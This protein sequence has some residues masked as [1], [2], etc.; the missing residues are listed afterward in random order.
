MARARIW[1]VILILSATGTMASA[2]IPRKIPGRP[3]ATSQPATAEAPAA[4]SRPA[5]PFSP[6]A[7]TLERRT[8]GYTGRSPVIRGTPTS[9]F[10]PIPD[11][12]R[13]GVPPE[14]RFTS[15]P[16]A[17][18]GTRPGPLEPYKQN[19]LKGDY[20]IFGQD[21]FLALSAT[22]D[23]LFETRRLPVPSGTSAK[24]ADSL[25]FFGAGRQYLVNQN[26]ILSMELF[27]GDTAYRPRDWELRFTPVFNFNYVNTQEL[28]LI[29]PD[30]HE[31][32]DR[33]DEWIGLQ[34][35]FF[36]KHLGDLSVNYDFW[37]ARFGIQGF[38]SDFR[39]FLFSDNE[40]GVRLFGTL[41]NFKTHWNVA[42]F[43]QL[44]KDT[45]SGLNAYELRDQ[46]VIIANIYRQDF[47]WLGYTA[48]LSFHANLDSGHGQID[49]NGVIVRPAPI[50]TIH[51]KSVNAYYLGWAGDGHIGRLNLTHQ[52]YWALG[53][54][55]FN[56]IAGRDVDINAQF[57]ALELSYDQDW[58]RY[59]ASFLW[60]SGDDDPFDSHGRGFD[61][62]FENPNFAGGG[63]SLFVRQSIKLTGAGVS[64]VNRNALL[65]DLRT[66]KEQG[67]ANFVNPGLFIYN[68]GADFEI[69]PK[70]KAITNV[71]WLM[72]DDTA[73]IQEL[74]GDD[75]IGRSIGLDYS[76]GLQW[77]PFLN[78]NAI[79]NFGAAALTPSNGFKDIYSSQTLYSVF[80]GVT[81]SY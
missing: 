55:S 14:S 53:H 62:I 66:S 22:S 30:V 54:E 67:Q 36:E 78:N 50:G 12:W 77:R 1:V 74:L 71:S 3:G 65:P 61:S 73:V 56:P 2:Q 19:V 20:P 7:Q 31:G 8:S 5:E 75:K 11:R 42:W 47:I 34:E 69:T 40:P 79:I 57:F 46:Q 15:E 70:L 17:F 43:S 37:A 16:G 44:E 64:L 35:L 49:D 29:D 52:F 27:E 60:A 51:E 80:L 26:F 38:T 6:P 32:R 24:D 81:L 41:D 45:N 39:G 68:V 33:H 76:V 72:F 63:T 25:A 48:Q 13:V 4:A 58:I 59:R 23:T 9:D 28:G 10:L 18:G 21:I